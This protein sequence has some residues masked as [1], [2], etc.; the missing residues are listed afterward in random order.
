MKLRALTMNEPNRLS[1]HSSTSMA[2]T[3]TIHDNDSDDETLSK[4]R[5]RLSIENVRCHVRN[6]SGAKSSIDSQ[7]Y[8]TTAGNLNEHL[9]GHS[10]R[11]SSGRPPKMSLGDGLFSCNAS[12]NMTSQEPEFGG[13]FVMTYVNSPIFRA[14]LCFQL[15]TSSPHYR[16]DL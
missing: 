8:Q 6:Y 4:N 5:A 1:C 9:Q 12:S 7:N 11:V 3:V 2:R 10:P 13:T 16:T 14:F 15:L